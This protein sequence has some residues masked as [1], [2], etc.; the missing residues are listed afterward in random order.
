MKLVVST[1]AVF[2]LVIVSASVILAQGTTSRVT[3][4]VTDTS[5]AA[6]SGAT[7]TLTNEATGISLTTTTGESGTYVFDLIQI[8]DYTVTVEKEGFKKSISKNN[9]VNINQPA[10]VNVALEVGDVSVSVTV[11][12]TVEAVTDKFFRQ[13]RKHGRTTDIGKFADCRT[14]RTQS[15]R[16]FEFS[17]RR[18]YRRKYRR[19]G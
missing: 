2:I 9:R 17:T 12:N 5:G 4:T 8:A 16:P 1:L 6:V 13:Y 14:A 15:A 19:R 3:G 18:S 7:V 10:T 11:E